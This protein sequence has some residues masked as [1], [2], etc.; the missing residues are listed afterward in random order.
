MTTKDKSAI[1][2]PYGRLEYC[3]GNEDDFW[4]FD[5]HMHGMGTVTLHACIN[6]ETGH[7][8]MDAENPIRVPRQDAVQ[9]AKRLTDLALDWCAMNNI[10][11]DEK[12]WNQDTSYFWRA[13]HCAV[14]RTGEAIRI[15]V[16]MKYRP[17][18]TRNYL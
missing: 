7:F 5:F 16:K 10:K 3:I 1:T 11:H 15:P 2:D 6:S 14:A 13:V 9:H 12:D 17:T 4:C 8:I 18:I